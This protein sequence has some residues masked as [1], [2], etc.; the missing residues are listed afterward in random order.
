MLKIDQFL[1]VLNTIQPEELSFLWEAVRESSFGEK[2][3]KI[4]VYEASKTRNYHRRLKCL[5]IY[6]CFEKVTVEFVSMVMVLKIEK[7]QSISLVF[8]VHLIL[9]VSEREAVDNLILAVNSRSFNMRRCAIIRLVKLAQLDQVF[10]TEVHEAL[11][12]EFDHNP[13]EYAYSSK[14]LISFNCCTKKLLLVLGTLRLPN[15]LGTI[16]L[17]FDA[18]TMFDYYIS[19]KI[20]VIE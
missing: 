3:F 2:N 10:T 4:A 14:E 6:I 1:R 20:P 13:A 11:T 7:P 15:Q 12:K 16:W 5:Q 9:S 8:T 18:S 19:K 17:D